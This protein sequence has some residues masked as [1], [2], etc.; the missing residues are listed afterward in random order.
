[1]NFCSVNHAL[2]G[3][4]SG[5]PVV[6]S[7]SLGTTMRMWDAQAAALAHTRLVLRYD[8]RARPLA[9]APAAL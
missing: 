1:V 7:N 6:L 4:A 3:P 8:T 9:R 2:E 5:A